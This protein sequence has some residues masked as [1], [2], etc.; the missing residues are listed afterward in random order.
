MKIG[1]VPSFI[2]HIFINHIKLLSY[3][4]VTDICTVVLINF[5]CGYLLR[6]GA[7]TAIL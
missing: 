2:L 4:F 3:L 7:S 6:L 5:I 1:G